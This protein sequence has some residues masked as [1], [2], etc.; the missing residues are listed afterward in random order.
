MF[1]ALRP[2]AQAFL[3]RRHGEMERDYTAKT[4]A[5]ATAINFASTVAPV[6]NDPRVAQSMIAVDG[7][8]ITPAHAIRE[9]AAMHVRAM[10]PDPR[11]RAGFLMDV[12]ERLQLDPAAVFGFNRQGDEP[13]IPGL[14]EADRQHPAFRHL[15]DQ[16]REQQAGIAALR[17]VLQTMHS[18]SQQAAS[19]HAVQVSR[20]GV[21]SFADEKDG[22]GNLVRPHFDLVL[23]QILELFKANPGRDL[24]E[25][26]E[27]AIWMNPDLRGTLVA[28]ERESVTRQQD[29]ARAAQAARMNTRG[30]TS[31]VSKPDGANAPKGLRATI[32]AAAEEVGL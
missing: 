22:S 2:E 28:R 6:F 32:E 16:I 17:G 23:P 19:R 24:R 31:P 8:P 30:R 14:S 29:A 12:A 9:W 15:T 21:D 11:V 5:N 3:L 26:Y 7:S 1:Q 25:A 13:P 4:Q 10:D 18:A 27:T 20:Q